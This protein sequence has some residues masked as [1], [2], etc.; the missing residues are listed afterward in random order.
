[1]YLGAEEED[2]IYLVSPLFPRREMSTLYTALLQNSGC[3][4]QFIYV[5]FL[6]IHTYILSAVIRGESD[7]ELLSSFSRVF[8]Y[9][10]V[11]ASVACIAHCEKAA[12][13]GRDL[14]AAIIR[15]FVRVGGVSGVTVSANR[16]PGD[17]LY[18]HILY[19]YTVV[20]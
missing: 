10:R 16:A 17:K 11:C 20:S 8:L 13:G 5:A 12:A 6:H 2:R 7:K 14:I 3:K 18:T 19:V 1:M 4:L 9:A 15:A